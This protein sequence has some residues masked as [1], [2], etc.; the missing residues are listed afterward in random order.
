MPKKLSSFVISAAACII[1]FLVC[2][3]YAENDCAAMEK[4]A[5][6]IEGVVPSFDENGKFKSIS[7]YAD[8]SFIAPKRSLIS[9][10]R[11]Q[12]ELKAKREFSNFIKE[13]VA[14]GT[15]SEYMMETKS[16]T[17][18]KGETSG[19]AEEINRISDVISSST[20]S[21]L[22]GIIKLDE[23]VDVEGK[24]VMVRMGWKPKLSK[25]A[26]DTRQTIDK[27]VARGESGSAEPSVGNNSSSQLTPSKGYRK[28]SSLANDF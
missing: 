28:K 10:A 5:E 7:M 24:F 22:S 26:A 21:V 9:A 4:E 11:K 1:L 16:V 20:E 2:P 18:D 17:S 23:C 12:A 27:E 13:K 14:S 3:V 25:I 15:L 19:S 6:A 8:G